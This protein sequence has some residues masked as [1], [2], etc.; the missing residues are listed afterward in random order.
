MTQR[1]PIYSPMNH[2]LGETID[3]LR[4]TVRQFASREI[5]PRAEEIDK[6][7]VFLQGN[8]RNLGTLAVEFQVDNLAR[9]W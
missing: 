2:S 3:L 5:A 7:D 8:W 4:D 1:R 6:T 9:G